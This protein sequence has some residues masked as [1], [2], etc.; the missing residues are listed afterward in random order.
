LTYIK[1]I[2]KTFGFVIR[3]KKTNEDAPFTT[4]GEGRQHA[5]KAKVFSLFK[6]A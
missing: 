4:C 5:L 3:N 1:A 2:H 6:R